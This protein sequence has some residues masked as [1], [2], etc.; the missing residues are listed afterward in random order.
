MLSTD[1][2]TKAWKSHSEADRSSH[3]LM[4]DGLIRAMYDSDQWTER[5]GTVDVTPGTEKFAEKELP[6]LNPD[7][8]RRKYDSLTAS[9]RDSIRSYFRGTN[10]DFRAILDGQYSA[11]Q[12]ANG[13]GATPPP[14][15]GVK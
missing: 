10:S 3:N 1:N 13:D 15:K 14:P 7:G 12:D 11:Q 4:Q 5:A 2:E 8:T 9:E 6:G